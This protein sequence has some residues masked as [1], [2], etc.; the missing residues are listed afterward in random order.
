MADDSLQN[1]GRKSVRPL[2]ILS[3]LDHY[4]LGRQ[5]VLTRAKRVDPK[6]VD[7]AGSD[8]NLLI[9]SASYMGAAVS[10]QVAQNTADLFLDSCEGEGLDRYV[11]DRYQLTRLGAAAAL[12]SVEFTRPTAT[13][14][15]G[16]IPIGT[17]LTTL[18]GIE[19]TTITQ[20]T[21]GSTDLSASCDVRAAQAGKDYQV[22]INAIRNFG[23]VGDI[24]DQTIQLNNSTA[25]AGGEDVEDDDTFK[26]RVRD[27]WRTARRG[28]LGAIEFGARSVPGVTSAMAV[29]EIGSFGQPVRVVRLFISDSSGVASRALAAKVEAALFDFRAGGIFVFIDLSQPQIVSVQLHLTFAAGVASTT[30]LAQQ[31]IAAVV[32]YINSLGVGQT[33]LRA[34]LYAVLARYK[35]DGLIVTDQT[36]V[37]PVGDLVPDTQHTLRTTLTF[38]QAA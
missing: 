6:V 12:G 25:P 31:V 24:F 33:L 14:G 20:A 38:V 30:T 9:G 23:T 13:A 18:T 15:S 19:Y 7:T 3:R 29:E 16:S 35:S 2:L 37:S 1:E 4:E 17:T 8:V 28:T 10:N 22:G 36:I 5:Y 27:F 32:E 21:F 34:D 26:N 11:F